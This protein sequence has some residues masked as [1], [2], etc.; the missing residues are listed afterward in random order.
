MSCPICFSTFGRI[1]SRYLPCHETHIFCD[2]C[3][4]KLPKRGL[5][6]KEFDCPLCK[7]AVKL[8]KKGVQGLKRYRENVQILEKKIDLVERIN[9][10]KKLDK[11]KM[12]S[13]LK[14]LDD[15][16][17]L[18]ISKKHEV[19]QICL[20]KTLDKISVLEDIL[21]RPLELSE[22]LAKSTQLQVLNTVRKDLEDSLKNPFQPVG[23]YRIKQFRPQVKLNS[24]PVHLLRSYK[25][26]FAPEHLRDEYFSENLQYIIRGGKKMPLQTVPEKYKRFLINCKLILYTEHSSNDVLQLMLDEHIKDNTLYFIFE[27]KSCKAFKVYPKSENKLTNLAFVMLFRRFDDIYLVNEKKEIC[28]RR[29]FLYSKDHIIIHKFSNS[30]LYVYKSPKTDVEDGLA[31]LSYCD[32]ALIN[33]EPEFIGKPSAVNMISEHETSLKSIAND[34]INGGLFMSTDK[35]IFIINEKD[36]SAKAYKQE[37]LFGTYLVIDYI[38]ESNEIKEFLLTNIL[39]AEKNIHSFKL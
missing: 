21:R 5:I 36:Y 35:Y 29:Y 19:I 38:R 20:I 3:I 16:V 32:V 34:I 12:E 28:F 25:S 23:L 31:E 27:W 1:T 22:T 13:I 4:D 15:F 14:E 7:S 10:L 26:S 24:K 2:S 17:D 18:C 11:R 8:P 37:Y 33:K 9:D 6:S 39:K 30:I